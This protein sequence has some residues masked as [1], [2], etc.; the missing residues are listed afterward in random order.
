[1]EGYEERNLFKR[2]SL[3]LGIFDG[4]VA[5][6]LE[7]VSFTENEDEPHDTRHPSALP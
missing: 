7:F 5:N 4:A 3:G 2:S 1:M 6:V